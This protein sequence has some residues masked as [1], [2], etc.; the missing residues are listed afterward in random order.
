MDIPMV[1]YFFY[2]SIYNYWNFISSTTTLFLC[3]TPIFVGQFPLSTTYFYKML[4]G[5]IITESHTGNTTTN[6]QTLFV[7][8]L[9]NRCSVTSHQWLWNKWYN[10]SSLVICPCYLHGDAWIEKLAVEFVL[11]AKLTFNILW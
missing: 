8:D 3:C 1:S 11:Y 9:N 4:C 2:D 10:W 7:H 6:L 5:F